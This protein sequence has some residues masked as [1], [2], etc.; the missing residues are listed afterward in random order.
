MAGSD[1]EGDNPPVKSLR[2]YMYPNRVFQ[3]SCIVLPA[4]TCIGSDDEGDNPPVKSLR[5]YMYP[6]RVFQPS[7]IVLPANRENENPYYHIRDFEE[8]CG[9]VKI[10][11]LSDEYLKLRLLPLSLK[12][13]AISWLDALAPSSVRTWEYMTKLFLNKFF[14]W[15]KTSAIRQKLNSFAQQQ[16]ESLCD[17]LE[18]F[19]DLLLQCPHHGFDTPRLTLILY[20]GLDHKTMTTVESLCAGNFQDKSVEEGYGFL[21]EVAEKTQEWD[22]K[23]PVRSIANSKGAHRVD[24]QFDS[25]AKI[26]SLTRRLESLEHSSK[27]KTFVESSDQTFYDDGSEQVN[28]LYQDNRRKCDPYSNTYNPGW[29]RH[30]DFS[31][32]RGQYEGQSNNVS[33]YTQKPS[34]PNDSSNQRMPSMEES[35]SLFM[36]AT[37]KSITNLEQTT[38]RSIANIERQVGQLASQMNDRDKG[39]F[40]SQ[41]MPNP[42]GPFEVSTSGAKS[43]DQVQAV[44]S[45]RSG[46]VIDNHV[47][48]PKENEHAGNTP[49]V[50][51]V[52]P[53]A[54]K[55]TNESEK[56]KYENT[57]VPRVPFP[58]RL[59]PVKINIPLLDAIKQIPMYA[60]FLKDMCTVKRNLDIQKRAFLA[61]QVSS[62]ITQ[63]T[64]PKYKDPGC[65]TIACTIGEHKIEHALLDLGASVNLLPYSMYEQ[66]GLGNLKP[67]NVTLQLADR[68]IKIPRGVVEDILVQIDSFIYPVDF[69]ILDTQPVAD[70][71]GQ[72]PIILGRPFLA[73]ANV[74]INCRNGIME[75]TFGSWK[76]EVNVFTVAR[77]PLD[78]N[79]HET[80]CMIDEIIHDTFL[81]N[82]LEDPL[83]ACL[84]HFGQGMNDDSVICPLMLFWARYE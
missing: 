52:T 33:G 56:D 78:F 53:S 24:I 34:I 43:S 59:L 16:G 13:K 72:I 12:D 9:T 75:L 83:E 32:S 3:P 41:T 62:I 11:N 70:P 29:A 55:E 45:L 31:W 28:A 15:Y 18:R 40:P 44:T 19:H 71:S 10:K 66:L 68:S 22:A 27:A 77:S 14:P 76:M 73:T 80:V 6:N 58:Q 54:Q 4:T 69:I 47:S 42:K 17:Y 57:Y 79:D 7:C 36:Q 50:T 81:Q 65:P 23:E 5:D 67:T 1:D 30:P 51:Q 21:Q 61:E 39:Q 35:L 38:A 46:R 74:I 49:I 82:H 25:D 60:K 20:E 8:L 64:L 63:K 2:D 48:N 84:T 26:S 37:Q